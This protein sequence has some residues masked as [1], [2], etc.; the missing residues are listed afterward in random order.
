[1]PAR[2]YTDE[3]RDRFFEVWIAVGRFGLLRPRQ[4]S[5]PTRAIGG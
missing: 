3:Q 5:V 1:M 4:E 2:K